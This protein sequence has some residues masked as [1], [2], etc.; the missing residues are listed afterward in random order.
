LSIRLAQGNLNALAQAGGRTVI[1]RVGPDGG[2]QFQKLRMH[3]RARTATRQM[4][5]DMGCL[6]RIQF[7]VQIRLQ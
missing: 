5:R 7:I 6:G 3:P 4:L 1:R 2:A